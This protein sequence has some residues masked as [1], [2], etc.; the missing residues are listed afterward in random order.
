MQHWFSKVLKNIEP[1]HCGGIVPFLLLSIG[2]GTTNVD[3]QG[4]LNAKILVVFRKVHCTCGM[5]IDKYIVH[6]AL[7]H[8]MK[9]LKD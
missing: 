1:E 3:S 6:M 8:T 7:Q 2:Y 4:I 9:A 5:Y